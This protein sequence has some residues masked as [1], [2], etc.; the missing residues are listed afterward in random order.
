MSSYPEHN[1]GDAHGDYVNDQACDHVYDHARH[2]HRDCDY[3]V[4]LP[5][6]FPLRL[7]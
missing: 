5:T 3:R 7:I 2:G 4:S 1:D 6:Y